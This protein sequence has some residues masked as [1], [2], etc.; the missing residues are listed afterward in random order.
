MHEVE[1]R[2]GEL[3]ARYRELTGHDACVRVDEVTGSAVHRYLFV[4]GADLRGKLAVDHLTC[5]VA[6]VDPS[7]R[8]RHAR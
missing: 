1:R 3:E 5:L 7:R 2:M 8:R 6:K 4:D